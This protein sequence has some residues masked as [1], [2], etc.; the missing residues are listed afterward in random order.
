MR[1]LAAGAASLS[2]SLSLA[3][4]LLA[5]SVAAANPLPVW[6]AERFHGFAYVIA[7]VLNLRAGPS[8]RHKDIGDLRHDAKLTLLA[9][10]K[11]RY[12]Q[13]GRGEFRWYQVQH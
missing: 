10:T 11:A 5:T 1:A 3:A 9:R 4:L 8:T 2:L 7:S 13:D 6:P 12:A